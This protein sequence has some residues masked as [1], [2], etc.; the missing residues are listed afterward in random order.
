MSPAGG[1]K[2]KEVGQIKRRKGSAFMHVIPF[3]FLVN[4]SSRQLIGESHYLF[5]C[6]HT[7]SIAKP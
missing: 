7:A 6:L 2:F 3:L 5:K 4:M 1:A